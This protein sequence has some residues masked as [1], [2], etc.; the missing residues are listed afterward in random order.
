MNKEIN[1]SIGNNYMDKYDIINQFNK[2]NAINTNIYF[3][4]YNRHKSDRPH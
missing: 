3:H 1:K 4:G 2:I